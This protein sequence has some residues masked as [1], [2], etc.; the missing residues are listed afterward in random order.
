MRIVLLAVKDIEPS[1]A[2]T[3]GIAPDLQGLSL[4]Q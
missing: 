2:V 4:S 3:L 1:I